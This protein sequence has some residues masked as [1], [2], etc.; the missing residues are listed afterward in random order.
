MPS[1]Y[2]YRHIE[3]DR[4]GAG[5]KR[6]DK[7]CLSS[8]FICHMSLWFLFASLNYDFFHLLTQGFL[9][10]CVF[11]VVVIL[12]AFLKLKQGLHPSST[13][14][15]SVKTF[16]SIS[17]IDSFAKVFNR[18]PSKYV[19]WKNYQTKSDEVQY[20]P[21]R[22][23]IKWRTLVIILVPWFDGFGIHCLCSCSSDSTKTINCFFGCNSW[24]NHQ[25]KA[26]NKQC[27]PNCWDSYP[28]LS[29]TVIFFVRWFDWLCFS[30]SNDSL[31]IKIMM[32][33]KK[34]SLFSQDGKR[35]I[36][37]QFSWQSILKKKEMKNT[38]K[39]RT[40]L[41]LK[42]V[43]GTFEHLFK[44]IPCISSSSRLKWQ[45]PRERVAER[46]EIPG[47]YFY[48]LEWRTLFTYKTHIENERRVRRE[49]CESDVFFLGCDTI[50]HWKPENTTL[51]PVTFC[52]IYIK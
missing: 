23:S 52:R 39:K 6:Y 32:D 47:I 26:S 25:T 12:V 16:W 31:K 5:K 20:L 48:C 13:W 50:W 21:D 11:S 51:L 22:N 41:Q 45:K 3:L 37:Q 38:K 40:L 14:G 17:S 49:K 15:Y 7:V 46:V 43:K 10:E 1:V 42:T 29:W 35:M 8:F 28:H 44:G 18:I 4:V 30:S 19:S 9:I 27:L 2:D 24:K 33:D 34:T 36:I